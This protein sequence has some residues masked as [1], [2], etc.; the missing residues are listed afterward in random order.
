MLSS[1]SMKKRKS[2]SQKRLFGIILILTILPF[3]IGISIDTNQKNIRSNAV[4]PAVA[5]QIYK[6]F[7]PSSFWYTPLPS[8][9]PIDPNSQTY[10]NG[11]VSQ[12][13]N[14]YSGKGDL[15]VTSYTPPV[16]IAG[17]STPLTN[18]TVSDCQK[19]GPNPGLQQQ[20]QNVPIPPEAVPAN[21][22]DAEM[23]VYSPQ[24][25]TYWDFW[26]VT[27][28]GNSFSACFGG[29]ISN[30]SQSEG[31][32]PLPYGTTATG[33]AFYGGLLTIPELKSGSINHVIGIGLVHTKKGIHSYPANRDDGC[34]TGIDAVPEGMRFRIDPKF[35]INTLKLHPFTKMLAIAAQKYGFVVWDTSGAVGFRVE[36]PL[37]YTN[38]GQTNPYK[39]IFGTTPTYEILNG[40][41]WDK[42]QALPFDYG[43]NVI[44]SITPEI[45]T[46][47]TTTPTSI[48]TPTNITPTFGCIGDC[49]T[50][51][52]IPIQPTQP[53]L[54]PTSTP[55]LTTVTITQNPPQQGNNKNLIQLLLSLILLIL[56][57]F[58]KLFIH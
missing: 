49:T 23:T 56:T 17:A 11:I 36:N 25:D 28:N 51:T 14:F 1:A 45:T 13:K 34:C 52:L 40:F 27:K 15:N 24:T 16:Y 12:V 55:S 10:V 42:L 43:K 3:L 4:I 50:P 18:V 33:L 29:K 20:F 41:P 22:T 9:T 39:D 31:I 37:P 2:K 8:N 38:A 53:L 21:G 32:F 19:L 26:R 57:F 30:A 46:A 44:P 54:E 7:S 5:Q 58:I 48:P 6:P 47:P 35:D